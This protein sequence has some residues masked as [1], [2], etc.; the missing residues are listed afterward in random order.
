MSRALLLMAL[1]A[2]SGAAPRSPVTGW[3]EVAWPFARDAWPAGRA[4]RCRD[5]DLDVYIRPKLGFCN[6]T[7]GVT[8]DAEVD[9]VS[10]LD[11]ISPE[12]DPAGPGGGVAAAGLLGRARDYTIRAPGGL[13][14]AV[15]VALSSQCDLLVAAA[16]GRD[17]DRARVTAL[18]E[19]AP[20]AAWISR[21]L[22][23]AQRS[24]TL[25]P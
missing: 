5:C 19:S 23:R 12:F 8:D 14:N 10:D 25:V 3:D 24:A 2:L 4:F 15:G 18:L 16:L 7:T 1:I 9:A 11:M 20:M 6:C 22:G 13:R 17:A 21:E